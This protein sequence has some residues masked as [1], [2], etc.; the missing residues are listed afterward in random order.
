M[1]A[2]EKSS[3]LQIVALLERRLPFLHRA[4]T[5]AA[6]PPVRERSGRL[7]HHGLHTLGQVDHCSCHALYVCMN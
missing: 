5:S 3:Q 2:G 1:Q 4:A 6:H 7:V